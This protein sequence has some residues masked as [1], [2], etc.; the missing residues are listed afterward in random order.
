MQFLRSGMPWLLAASLL[1]AAQPALAIS[2]DTVPT[3]AEVVAN[4]RLAFRGEVIGVRHELTTSPQLQVLPYTAYTFLVHE[5]YRG[6]TNRA[7]VTLFQFG[8]PMGED[9]V[10]M[11]GVP[12]L[13]LG[14]Q[15][16]IFANDSRQFL[17]AT[18]WAEAGL[19]RFVQY[20]GSTILLSASWAPMLS[21]AN[22]A[23]LVNQCEPDPSWPVS[24][25]AWVDADGQ[26]QAG[27]SQSGSVGQIRTNEAFDT[28]VFALIAGAGPPPSGPAQTYTEAAWAAHLGVVMDAIETPVAAP[29]P[30]IL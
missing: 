29:N 16:A 13:A 20:S 8:G 5:A 17:T 19:R 4:S 10:D 23:S 24:C 6:T 9:W 3:F 2:F 1:A 15:V 21:G 14:E 18:L 28:E 22:E 11:A 12:E 25:T 7:E 26:P 27:P 30:P